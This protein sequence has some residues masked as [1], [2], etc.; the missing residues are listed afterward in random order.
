MW[1]YKKLY[2]YWIISILLCLNIVKA[3]FSSMLKEA[4]LNYFST[5]N[6][7]K[8]YYDAFEFEWEKLGDKLV[9]NKDKITKEFLL[10]W[11][12]EEFFY[13][14]RKENIEYNILYFLNIINKNS[15][16]INKKLS[17]A[18][19]ILDWNINNSN[20]KYKKLFTIYFKINKNRINWLPLF[21]K[22]QYSKSPDLF[23]KDLYKL[24]YIL[25]LI[26]FYYKNKDDYLYKNSLWYYYYWINI[27]N[28]ENKDIRQLLKQYC[29]DNNQDRIYKL[30]LLLYNLNK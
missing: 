25:E 17:E 15:F 26:K 19:I 13:K 24:S 14:F 29:I 16:E 23:F 10:S 30:F 2:I 4:V 5:S 8:Y 11:T 1:K 12:K 3:N 20:K 21:V 28:I 22:K 27:V 9:E 7:V 6:I 18:L